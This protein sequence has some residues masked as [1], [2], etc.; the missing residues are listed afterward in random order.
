MGTRTGAGRKVSCEECFFGRNMLCALEPREPC[1]A[2]R[3]Y[4]PE[5]LRPPRQLR[6]SFRTEAPGRASWAFPSAEEQ[7][8]LYA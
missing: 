3:P 7:A 5:G 6:F 8:A 2:F 1:A 4:D